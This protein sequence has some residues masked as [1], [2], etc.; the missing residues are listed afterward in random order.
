[1]QR[2]AAAPLWLTPFHFFMI[3]LTESSESVAR[4]DGHIT[5]RTTLGGS[6]ISERKVIS[7]VKVT[8]AQVTALRNLWSFAKECGDL[9]VGKTLEVVAH[10]ARGGTTGM[11]SGYLMAIYDVEFEQEFK[12][13]Y[14]V[15]EWSL[16]T[17][18][19]D[20]VYDILA[21]KEHAEAYEDLL[22]DVKAG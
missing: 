7:V 12:R 6:F 5:L 18:L 9:T 13:A 15:Q 11:P 14:S 8:N 1:M 3:P 2:I 20:Q 19:I 10:V 16:A 22:F 4:L 21:D 17:D